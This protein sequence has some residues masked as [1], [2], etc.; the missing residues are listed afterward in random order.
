MRYVANPTQ[1][2][3]GKSS[4]DAILEILC[5]AKISAI[6]VTSRSIISMNA[7]AMKCFAKKR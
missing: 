5:V 1:I 6:R 4:H 7:S 2:A 3:Y